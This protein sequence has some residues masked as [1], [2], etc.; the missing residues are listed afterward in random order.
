MTNL[1]LKCLAFALLLFRTVCPKPVGDCN[2]TTREHHCRLSREYGFNLLDCHVGGGVNVSQ[3]DFSCNNLLNK[4]QQV[5]LTLNYS[6]TKLDQIINLQSI[7]N[8]IAIIGVVGASEF[9]IDKSP[10]GQKKIA[11]ISLQACNWSFYKNGRPIVTE[12]DCS[13]KNFNDSSK[14]I[15]H[16]FNELQFS[17]VNFKTAVCPFILKDVRM[18]YVYLA[19]LE[20]IEQLNVTNV[21]EDPNVA[22]QNLVFMNVKYLRLSRRVLDNWLF[23]R[24]ETII[25]ESV[26]A[27]DLEADALQGLPYVNLMGFYDLEFADLYSRFKS[28]FLD[29]KA[30]KLNFQLTNNV[31]NYTFIKENQFTFTFK[32]QSNVQLYSEREFCEYKDFPHSNAVLVLFETKIDC[33]NCLHLFLSLNNLIIGNS[34]T[35]NCI[36][37]QTLVSRMFKCNFDKLLNDCHQNQNDDTATTTTITAGPYVAKMN[38]TNYIREMA[39]QLNLSIQVDEISNE[40]LMIMNKSNWHLKIMASLLYLILI[41]YF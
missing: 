40:A 22:I 1:L 30:T 8:P 36:D 21:V 2:A 24:T 13:W 4:T 28:F 19:E 39:K 35:H 11:T 7:A 23:R 5:M 38:Y 14:S 17:A 29:P 41:F 10:F 25:I 32:Q 31:F 26:A 3:M 6:M 20:S 33:H 34:F 18:E 16:G 27:L 15:F 12:S 37:N 9:H